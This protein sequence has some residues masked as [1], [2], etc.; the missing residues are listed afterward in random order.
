MR[1]Y[2]IKREKRF[3]VTFEYP[4]GKVGYIV[5]PRPFLGDIVK[6]LF[7]DPRAGDIKVDGRTYREHL[8]IHGGLAIQ[9]LGG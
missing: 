1:T 9:G 8:N 6:T 2:H 5:V 3:K 7:I 4:D